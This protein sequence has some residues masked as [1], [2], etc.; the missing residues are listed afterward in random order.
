[1]M[2]N[3]IAKQA[4]NLNWTLSSPMISA[5][6]LEAQPLFEN[7]ILPLSETKLTECAT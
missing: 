4:L 2:T 3:P 1:M 6:T 7:E 5:E